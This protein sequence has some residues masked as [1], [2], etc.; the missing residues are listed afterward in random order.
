MVGA[1][2]LAA[3]GVVAGRWCSTWRKLWW[4]TGYVVSL[5]LVTV[6][7]VARWFPRLEPSPPFAWVMADR[8]EFALPARLTTA[9]DADGVCVRS[10][11]YCL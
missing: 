6:I 9:V 3:A 4:L 1:I 7:A 8:L 2:G 11:S 10:N 5:L